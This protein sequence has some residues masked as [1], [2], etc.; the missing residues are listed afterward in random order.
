MKNDTRQKHFQEPRNPHE[1]YLQITLQTQRFYDVG[2]LYQVVGL[3]EYKL[4]QEFQNSFS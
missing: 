4:L 1:N 2:P 3:S